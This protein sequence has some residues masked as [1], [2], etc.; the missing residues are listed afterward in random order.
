MKTVEVQILHGL[1]ASGKTYY[2]ESVKQSRENVNIVPLDNHYYCGAWIEHD[3]KLC[4]LDGLI[5]TNEDIV[6]IIQKA[7]H[8]EGKYVSLTFKI[9]H[10]K[11][12]RDLCLKNDKNRRS[13]SST[14]T[15][16]SAEFE[17]IDIDYIKQKTGVDISIEERT[18]VLKPDYVFCIE[19]NDIRGVKGDY[20]FSDSWVISGESRSYDSDWQPCYSCI[21]GDKPADFEELYKFLEAYKPDL[22]A[23]QLRHIQKNLIEYFEYDENDYYSRTRKGQYKINMKDLLKYIDK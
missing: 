14:D 1:P 23:L 4:I 11:E 8:Y 18:I 21:G 9:I 10:W 17:K 20:M 7:K 2:A 16:K 12:N 15:I 5:L 3:T 19:E 13:Q 22:T 6:K